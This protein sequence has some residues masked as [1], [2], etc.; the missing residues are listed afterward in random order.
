[1]ERA[2]YKQNI[3]DFIATGVVHAMLQL[4]SAAVLYATPPPSLGDRHF[5]GDHPG[6]RH[7]I[8]GEI[9]RGA[10]GYLHRRIV[11]YLPCVHS[12]HT[13]ILLVQLEVT[14][15]SCMALYGLW[16]LRGMKNQRQPKK[17][18]LK[19]SAHI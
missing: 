1:M 5:M 3:D 7:D 14:S 11:E 19:K 2:R 15:Q 12:M 17:Q 16:M 18:T 6:E 9:A 8:R 10:G 13:Q 4:S